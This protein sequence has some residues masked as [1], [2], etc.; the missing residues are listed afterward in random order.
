M[1]STEW[2]D[3]LG[4]SRAG[5]EL[6]GVESTGLIQR[7]G[8]QRRWSGV[9]IAVLRALPLRVRRCGVVSI[10]STVVVVAALFIT[11]MRWLRCRVGV[12]FRSGVA[13]L[14]VVL[15]AV[16]RLGILL[17]GLVLVLSVLTSVRIL[18]C[19]NNEEEEV[20]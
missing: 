5:R 4:P 6:P 12:E 13:I 20:K 7:L 8:C 19:H 18:I 17:W 15:L 1:H 14:P 3:S 2:D 9:H 11:L 16:L 10:T